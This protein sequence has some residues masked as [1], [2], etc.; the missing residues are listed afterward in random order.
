MEMLKKVAIEA[1]TYVGM[2]FALWIGFE[3][4][5]FAAKS[6]GLV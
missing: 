6:I 5:K 4:A 3:L 2:G 1:I